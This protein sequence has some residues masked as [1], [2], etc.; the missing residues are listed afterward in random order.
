MRVVRADGLL[1]TCRWRYAGVIAADLVAFFGIWAV[2]AY[3][4]ATWWALFL[5]VP[6][7]IFS[8][9]LMFLGHDVGHRQIARTAR[10]NG[11]LQVLFGDLLSGLSHKWWIDKHSKHHANPNH[12][13]KDPDVAPGALA[14]TS[15][16]ASARKSRAGMWAAKYQGSLFFPM[17]LLEALNLKFN[18]FKAARTVRDKVFLGIHAFTYIGG[19][20]LVLGPGRAAVFAVI[21]HALVGLHLGTAFAPNHKGMAMIGPD[22]DHD[23]LRKQVLTSRNVRGGPAVDWMMGGLNYQIEHHLFPSLPRPHLRRVQVLVRRHCAELDVP[24][25]SE[26]FGTSMAMTV[27]HIHNAGRGKTEAV[28]APAT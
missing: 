6:A 19:L 18:S 26:N 3:L 25:A 12:V 9:R 15:E 7:A 5:A 16:Q 4:G 1:R 22:A 14:W 20:V 8:T 27:R 17:L 24:Y 23:F 28:L 11:F 21:H 10:G 13:G 2:L